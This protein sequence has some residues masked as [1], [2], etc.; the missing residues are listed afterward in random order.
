MI[1]F[2]I[3]KKRRREWYSFVEYREYEKSG[4]YTTV[5]FL[6]FFMDL[7]FALGLLFYN[8]NGLRMLSHSRIPSVTP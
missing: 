1:T 3:K 7:T 6:R 8:R 5:A 4:I 2:F